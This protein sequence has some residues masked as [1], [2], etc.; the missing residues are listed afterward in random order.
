MKKW[1]LTLS[2]SLVDVPG[3]VLPYESIKSNKTA[4][5]GGNEA[6]WTKHLRSLPMFICATMK[7][8][9]ILAPQDC[10]SD[11][12]TFAMTL[13]KAARGMSFSL[14]QPTM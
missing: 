6:D 4:Y 1:N 14:P 5:D 9:I 3:R 8:W 13:E 7:T 2:N 11:V 10:C 12:K